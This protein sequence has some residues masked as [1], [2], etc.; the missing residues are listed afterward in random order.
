M[1]L[2]SGQA[3]AGE[4]NSQDRFV[5][6]AWPLAPSEREGGREAMCAAS[7]ICGIYPA[8]GQRDPRKIGAGKSETLLG[9]AVADGLD[10]VL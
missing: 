4:G 1:R 7:Y 5:S 8:S 6:G 9:H 2:R 3:E 10:G